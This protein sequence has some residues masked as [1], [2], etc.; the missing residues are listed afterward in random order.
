MIG[1]APADDLAGRHI[2]YSSQ[3]QP[4]LVSGDIRNLPLRVA[5]GPCEPDRVGAV[6]LE[7]T[8]EQVRGDTVAVPAVGRDRRPLP[9]P[10]WPKPVFPHE[11]GDPLAG[12]ANAV[13][14]QFGMDARSPI[15]LATVL[16]NTSDL[17][18]EMGLGAAL[19]CSGLIAGL[20]VMEPAA[21][22][23]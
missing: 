9:A 6:S 3:V 7:D 8:L 14:L 1:H 16:E 4:A 20:P 18:N 11:S 5:Q 17:T 22:H 12:D 23:A 10:G 2:L 21:R 15:A 13:G 19:R